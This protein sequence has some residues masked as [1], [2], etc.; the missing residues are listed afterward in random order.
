[1]SRPQR[2]RSNSSRRGGPVRPTTTDI[3]REPAPLPDIDMITVADDPSAL[4]RSLGEPPVPDGSSAGERF[5]MVVDRA[6]AIAAALA[7][8]AELLADEPD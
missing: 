4:V 2:Q 8:S 7:L 6:A 1:M 3:W 5:A